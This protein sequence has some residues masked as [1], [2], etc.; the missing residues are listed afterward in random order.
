M[1]DIVLRQN[2]PVRTYDGRLVKSSE[3]ERM[4]I[5]A[6]M[7]SLWPHT[8]MST[9][10]LREYVRLTAHLDAEQLQAA[11]DDA[12]R[13]AEFLP[14]IGAILS[15]YQDATDRARHLPTVDMPADDRPT[16]RTRAPKRYETREEHA[17]RVAGMD[18]DNYLDEDGIA[19]FEEQFGY[20]PKG[21]D[22]CQWGIVAEPDMDSINAPLWMAR[23][24]AAAMGEVVFCTCGA[25]H[26][27]ER[28]I[29]EILKKI[30]AMWFDD[31]P[32]GH[33]VEKSK[34]GGYRWVT[35]DAPK[36]YIPEAV[37]QQVR[38]AID[39]LPTFHE[40]A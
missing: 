8:E 31:K 39:T 3:P 14:T 15:K 27:E 5:L 6:R 30:P 25:G 2:G 1:S 7:F 34:R 37:V 12:V 17:D 35:G 22:K 38:A 11:V 33:M 29:G 28:R 21:C 26:A 18:W 19:F 23:A 4:N 20:N 32:K 24:T 36:G 16:V 13:E 10:A 40:G 9:P